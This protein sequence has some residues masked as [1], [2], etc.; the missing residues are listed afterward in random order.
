MPVKTSRQTFILVIPAYNEEKYIERTI[1]AW[2]KSLDGFPGSEILVINDGSTDKTPEILNLLSKK[3]HAVNIIHKKNEGHGK[4][5]LLGYQKAVE[6]LHDWVFQTDGDGHF[7]PN[8]FNKLW[9]KRISSDFILGHRKLR[10]DSAAR[11]A[12][13]NF[14]SFWI[15]LLFGLYIKD[16]NIP[17]RLIKRTYLKGILKRIPKTVFAPNMF[18][19]IL[20]AKDGQKLHHV[21][22]KHALRKK[23]DNQLK[24]FRGG[25]RTFFE[26]LL[27]SLF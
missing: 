22:V 21:P 11:I 14:A 1:L 13:S 25:M 16:P 18:L 2:A 17:F 20:A 4:T 6:S 27:F 19:S 9:R 8:D 5:I 23:H 10:A 24:L 15:Y 12:L 3:L 26:L 7:D